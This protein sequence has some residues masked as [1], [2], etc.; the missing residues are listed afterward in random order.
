MTRTFYTP[1]AVLDTLLAGLD[2]IMRAEDFVPTWYLC[3]A[4]IWTI[5]YGITES[6]LRMMGLD[7]SDVPGP[8]TEPQARRLLVQ[9][10]VGHVEPIIEH[11]VRVPLTPG[12]FSA[13]VSFVYN[14][15][16]GAFRSSTLLRLLNEGRH[17]EA[18]QQLLR[19]V[20]ADGKRLRGLVSRRQAELA[21]YLQAS[22]EH[23]N[24]S[25]ARLEPLPPTP[26]APGRLRLRD[27]ALL[28]V[29]K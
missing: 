22:E 6:A 20:Y 10:V 4:R 8:I 26:I 2:L 23:L 11:A 27:R 17:T 16:A 19:W 7:R 24:A 1:D 15:G 5:G 14:V 25:L 18:G 12:E 3:P 9:F 28:A 21:L 29:T 13:L